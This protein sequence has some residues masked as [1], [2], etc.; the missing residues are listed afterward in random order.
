MK[1]RYTSAVSTAAEACVCV[2]V[3]ARLRE[4]LKECLRVLTGNSEC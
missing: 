4:T 1:P 2:S 3:V